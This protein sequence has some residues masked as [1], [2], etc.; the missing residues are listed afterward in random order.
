MGQRLVIHIIDEEC[1]EEIMNVYYH[2][3][4]YTDSAFSEVNKLAR[5]YAEMRNAKKYK[6]NY[7]ALFD[8]L[9]KTGASL[10]CVLNKLTEAETRK[11]HKYLRDICDGDL[12][13]MVS[14]IDRDNGLIAVTPETIQEI[15][16]WSEGDV[17]LQMDSDGAIRLNQFDIYTETFGEDIAEYYGKEKYVTVKKA[18]NLFTEGKIDEK[19][20]TKICGTIGIGTITS[21]GFSTHIN[22]AI[23]YPTNEGWDWCDIGIDSND[24][25][26]DYLLLDKNEPDPVLYEVIM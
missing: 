14:A 23:A 6:N 15:S 8:A 22:D 24:E 18:F 9:Y 3:S 10:D 25:F 11:L 13:K 26:S 19:E 1:Q 16:S 2:W 21:P 12:P 7:L 17:Y 5:I 4:A 20:A